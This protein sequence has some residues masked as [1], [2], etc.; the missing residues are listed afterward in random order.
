[1]VGEPVTTKDDASACSG[2]VI[3]DGESRGY[4][5]SNPV[6]LAPNS[7]TTPVWTDDELYQAYLFGQQDHEHGSHWGRTLL[8]NRMRKEREKV[9][10]ERN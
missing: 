8:I 7:Q 3:R 1:M 4:T 9:R 6:A 10:D 2:M 5:G